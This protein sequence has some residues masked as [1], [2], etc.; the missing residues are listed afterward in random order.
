MTEERFLT[1]E[2]AAKIL[3]V[4]RSALYEQVRQKQFPA[5]RVGK[6]IRI[7]RKVIFG[8]EKQEA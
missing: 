2:E 7:D 4:S 1:V 5:V 3:R 6:A 8:K